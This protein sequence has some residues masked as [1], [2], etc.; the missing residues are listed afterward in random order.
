MLQGCSKRLREVLRVIVF[1][2]GCDL[3]ECIKL[4][5]GRPGNRISPASLPANIGVVGPEANDTTV[6]ETHLI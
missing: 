4:R 3:S 1:L 6:L 2:D 5:A